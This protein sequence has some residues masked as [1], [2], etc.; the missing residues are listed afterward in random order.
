MVFFKKSKTDSWPTRL[1]RLDGAVCFE[2]AL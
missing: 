2:I 1:E